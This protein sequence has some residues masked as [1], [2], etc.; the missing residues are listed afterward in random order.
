MNVGLS[1][2][3]AEAFRNEKHI[4]HILFMGE[5]RLVDQIPHDYP[6]R[7]TI[8]E[9][10]NDNGGPRIS[11]YIDQ[12][13]IP[14]IT[15]IETTHT[16][17][18]LTLMAPNDKT[19]SITGIY[20]PPKLKAK[21]A[22]TLMQSIPPTNVIMGDTNAGHR[23]WDKKR[24]NTHGTQ[25]VE[26]MATRKLTML[27]PHMR[28]HNRSTIDHIWSNIPHEERTYWGNP[29]I[30]TAPHRPISIQFGTV[31]PENTLPDPPRWKK[32]NW[33]GITKTMENQHWKTAEQLDRA[34][35]KAIQDNIPHT[36]HR[37][38]KWK[39]NTLSTM[40]ADHRK[41][42][43]QLKRGTITKE[44]Y[45][46]ILGRLRQSLADEANESIDNRLNQLDDPEVFQILKKA[47]T[48]NIIPT[49][50]INGTLH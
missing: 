23:E 20:W 47:K 41:A 39:S 27:N 21:D 48:R 3:T 18:T 33:E 24:T 22:R 49:F 30:A 9:P 40:K 34:V 12:R 17:I 13:T 28:T 5:P 1:D 15:S 2:L 32:A 29:L 35:R 50:R 7:T 38:T 31:A 36:A 45:S 25:L 10:A 16:A 4:D 44:R 42:R 46:E 26:E 43:R 6:G 14:R 11:A 8:C 37:K 19:I